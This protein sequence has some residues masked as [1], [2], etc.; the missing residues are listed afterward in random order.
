MFECSVVSRVQTLKREFAERA[1]QT[2]VAIQ[3][4]DACVRRALHDWPTAAASSTTSELVATLQ[5]DTRGTQTESVPPTP[6]PVALAGER[7]QRL[8]RQR[9]QLSDK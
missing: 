7:V 8:L 5:R 1:A 4:R 6:A 3:T 2:T 9:Q